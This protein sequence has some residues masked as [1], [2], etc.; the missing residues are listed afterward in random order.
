MFSQFCG[1]MFYSLND[2]FICYILKKGIWY[3][4]CCCST[5]CFPIFQ[6]L[7]LPLK[8]GLCRCLKR[9]C[10][11]NNF[12][13]APAVFSRSCQVKIG[14]LD[15]PEESVTENFF[16]ISTH[17]ARFKNIWN[18]FYQLWERDNL[19]VVNTIKLRLKFSNY[20]GG[21]KVVNT[22]LILHLR[23]SNLMASHWCMATLRVN[24]FWWKFV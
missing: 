11:I 3:D 18:Y 24:P 20:W 6:F 9:H 15:Q 5:F 2:I 7:S 4:F 19:I 16:R 14:D 8:R 22:K 17:F 12:T 13:Q 1:K 23:P 10:V 21:H